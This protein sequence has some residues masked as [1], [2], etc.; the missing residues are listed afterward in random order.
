MNAAVHADLYV[1]AW[2]PETAKSKADHRRSGQWRFYVVCEGKLPEGQNTISLNP[3]KALSEEFT[4]G[5]LADAINSAAAALPSLK[6]NLTSN[7]GSSG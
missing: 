1:F 4:Y 6:S 3:I 7:N 5:Q 2:H